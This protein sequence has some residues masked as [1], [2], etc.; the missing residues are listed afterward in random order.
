MLYY[1][2]KSLFW[3]F[4]IFG[5]SSFTTVRGQKNRFQ[6][7]WM[8][9]IFNIANFHVF[10][11]WGKRILS[12]NDTTLFLHF[13]SF[14]WFCN[15][16]FFHSVYVIKPP[17]PSSAI[18]GAPP[19]TGN[20]AKCFILTTAVSSF[21]RAQKMD[22][23][24]VAHHTTVVSMCPTLRGANHFLSSSYFFAVGV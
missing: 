2:K 9:K 21:A 1:G 11:V 12:C 5:Y 15:A 23:H 22:T 24:T 7:L 19:F 16:T 17:Q 10:H 4:I 3:S 18:Y 6:Q 14:F 20:R 8:Y 13:F